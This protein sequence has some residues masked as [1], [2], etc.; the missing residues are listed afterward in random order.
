VKEEMLLEFADAMQC[1]FLTQMLYKDLNYSVTLVSTTKHFD[2][3]FCS[4]SRHLG[5][6]DCMNVCMHVDLSP[7]CLICC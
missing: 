4:T 2:F 5:L 7:L 3:T 6:R 1:N